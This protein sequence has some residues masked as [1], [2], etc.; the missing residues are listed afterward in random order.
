MNGNFDI[1]SI[2]N[3]ATSVLKYLGKRSFSFFFCLSI[4]AN[5]LKKTLPTSFS[6]NI[7]T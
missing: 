1:L 3:I 4:I 2:K 6:L 7:F 5:R